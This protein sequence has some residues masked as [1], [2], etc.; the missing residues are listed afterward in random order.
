MQQLLWKKMWILRQL[1]GEVGAPVIRINGASRTETGTVLKKESLKWG[2]PKMGVPNN[3]GF[4]YT[5][6]CHF[7]V[8]WGYHHLRKHLNQLEMLVCHVQFFQK[9]M[10]SFWIYTLNAHLWSLTWLL[11]LMILL[12]VSCLAAFQRYCFEKPKGKTRMLFFMFIPTWGDDPIW[13]DYFSDGWFN[14]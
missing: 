11:V 8:F 4:S 1:A 3:Q 2:F 10:S 7:V 9:Q 13:R 12:F 6:N 14:H 5:K